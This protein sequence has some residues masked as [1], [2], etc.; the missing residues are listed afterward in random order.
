MDSILIKQYRFVFYRVDFVWYLV[1]RKKFILEVLFSNE[2]PK[3]IEYSK[4]L[5]LR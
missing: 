2:T 3:T 5:K 1:F 4:Y